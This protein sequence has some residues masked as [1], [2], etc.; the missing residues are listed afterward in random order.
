M[1]RRVHS[2]YIKKIRLAAAAVSHDFEDRSI[3]G[4][5]ESARFR[6]KKQLHLRNRVPLSFHLSPSLYKF[7][8]EWARK[9]NVSRSWYILR[10]VIEG[11]IRDAKLDP[12]YLTDL[13]RDIRATHDRPLEPAKRKA[14]R[15]TVRALVMEKREAKQDAADPL[16]WLRG[17]E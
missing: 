11:L 1:A 14:R 17:L 5:L 8:G 13:D 7:L 9:A 4:L 10:C 15:A 16:G 2:K 3:Q 6:S 12:Q